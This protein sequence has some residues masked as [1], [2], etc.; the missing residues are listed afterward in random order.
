MGS[1]AFDYE[2]AIIGGGPAGLS[3][4]LLL[5]RSCRRV[6]VFDHGQPR[7]YAATAVHG[8]LGRD[9][10][11]PWELRQI[12]RQEAGRYGVEFID[13]EATACEQLAQP[14]SDR[15]AFRIA[16]ERGEFR[17]RA[18]LLATGT[19]DQLP[20]IP[21]LREQFGKTV[22]H[23]PYCD[24]WE[25]RGQR[26]I[27][28][29]SGEKATS[30]GRTLQGWSCEVAVCTDGEPLGADDRA[31][32]ERAG[33]TVHLQKIAAV[34][35]ARGGPP[36]IVFDD[37]ES[38]SY[39]GMFF[40]T[41]QGQQSALAKMLGCDCDDKDLVV[42]RA[43]QCTSVGGVFLAG[44]ADGDVQFSIVAAAEGAIAATAIHQALLEQDQQRKDD[45]GSAS[46]NA[47]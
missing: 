17:V 46:L 31:T 9:G 45:A 21:G 16:T 20:D 23:C 5:G 25:H 35:A 38:L 18:I 42:T 19:I 29:G 34:R 2:V 36:C 39:D 15:T 44:D 11:S 26:L 32:L 28:L 10:V 1:S 8:Y 24:G 12:G 40:S 33:I 4:A 37:G 41:G 14:G 27:A 43:K 13:G 3:A 22:H 6:V 47:R 30:L 7:N